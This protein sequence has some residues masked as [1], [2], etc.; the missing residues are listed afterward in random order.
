MKI[1]D[2][3]KCL[4]DFAPA[5]LQED[6]DNAGLIVGNTIDECKGV[7]VT[8]DVTE[9]IIAEA[10]K[11]KCNLIVA[12][13][14]IIFKSLK[15]ING[16]NYVERTIIAA[17]K[18]NVAIYAIHTNLD[19]VLN[20][21]NYKIAQ[22]LQLQNIQVLSSKKNSLKKLVTF[23][24]IDYAEE[25]RNV[26]FKTGAGTIG[27]YSE[28]S[29]NIEGWGTFKANE[30]TKPFVGKKGTRHTE[31]ET[32]IEVIFPD[33]LQQKMIQN[34]KAAHPYEEVAYDIYFLAN[35][36]NDIGSGIIGNL[37]KA[38][39]EE[40]LLTR[41]KKE[42]K[43]TVIRH[44]F[45]LHKKITKVAL[46]GGAGSFLIDAAK[47]AGAQAFITSDL[48]Y[49]EFFDADKMIFLADIGHF[50]SEQFTVELLVEILQEKF[51]NFAVLKTETNTNPVNYFV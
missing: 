25:I 22:K 13:H 20:G 37:H 11:K 39:S 29:Y 42:F 9:K 23:S 48:K 14:P 5:A 24:P 4:E 36:R 21:V 1:S 44:T 49:H 28:C 31:N 47:E 38:I 2:I 7:L 27:K 41:L 30:N 18:N 12:H 3:I 10:Q 34:L 15:K 43:L 40:E 8:L 16:K 45:F 17:I 35:E 19:N 26:L 32:R 33:H 46:C 50:E 6:Y 51:P